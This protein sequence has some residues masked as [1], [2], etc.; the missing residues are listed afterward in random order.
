MRLKAVE[1]SSTALFCSLVLTLAAGCGGQKYSTATLERFGDTKIGSGLAEY[2]DSAQEPVEL[3]IQLAD[4]QPEDNYWLCLNALAAGGAESRILGSLRCP[5]W[6][7]GS[8]DTSG[9]GYWDFAV[10]TAD[11]Q[12]RYEG[13]F[14]LPLPTEQKPCEMKLLVKDIRAGG[15]VILQSPLLLKAKASPSNHFM[16]LVS[17]VLVTCLSLI[18]LL[19][20]GLR[21]A[22]RRLGKRRNPLTSNSGNQEG[23][24]T[25]HG[26]ETPPRD[27][28]IKIR[29]W[30]DLGIGIGEDRKYL[31]VT[32]C[33]PIGGIF[34]V[35]SAAEISLQG[36]QWQELLRLL[37]ESEDGKRARKEDVMCA[38]KY[39]SKGELAADCCGADLTV[40]SKARKRLTGAIADRNR[41]LRDEHIDAIEADV[42][43]LSVAEP[44]W[45]TS[46]FVVRYLL[47]D[48]DG[49]LRFGRS[50]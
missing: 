11:H 27:R 9:E 33:P 28:V 41:N 49:K 3:R 40:V 44:V 36:E 16:W 46:R 5:G 39:L 38:F 14:L 6:P 13:T 17:A 29:R 26:D 23:T 7:E 35:A 32:P 2:P 18:V 45:V 24:A 31:A 30:E 21:R 15:S 8:F 25:A 10:I 1:A 20:D 42:G 48:E 50:D 43:P 34:P 4:L 19:H 12:G 37:A 47:R 22:I